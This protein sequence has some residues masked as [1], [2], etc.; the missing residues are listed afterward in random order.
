MGYARIGHGGSRG[1]KFTRWAELAICGM[2]GAVFR[3]GVQVKPG[4]K[5][6]GWRSFEN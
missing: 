1:G 4:D 2:S 6:R 3:D 5:T